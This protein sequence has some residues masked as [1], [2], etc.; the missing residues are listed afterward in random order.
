M[1][2]C[3]QGACQAQAVARAK[4]DTGITGNP[5]NL[6]LCFKDLHRLPAHIIQADFMSLDGSCLVCGV[7]GSHGGLQ[8][9]T[10]APKSEAYGFQ[11]QAGASS[12]TNTLKPFGD[13]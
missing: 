10:L 9:P 5:A 7:A 13:K 6:A 8:C 12:S 3:E 11:S 2:Y 1:R 4:K